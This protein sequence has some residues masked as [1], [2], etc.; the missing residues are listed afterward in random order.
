VESSPPPLDALQSSGAPTLVYQTLQGT[1][2]VSASI[3]NIRSPI[4][5]I[6]RDKLELRATSF[7]KRMR[8]R[9]GWIAPLGAAIPILLALV[10]TTF[11]DVILKKDQ[12]QLVFIVGL[13]GTFIWL[14]VAA[15]R[16]FGGSNMA[17]FLASVMHVDE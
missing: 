17:D 16:A 8:A 11:N 1:T 5:T 14:V 6:T 7:L 10:T 13:V 9:E 12:W 3:Q 2:L 15:V 4:I